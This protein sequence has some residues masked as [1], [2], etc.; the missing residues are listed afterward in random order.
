[1]LFF[2][3][4]SIDPR[5]SDQ[6][7]L[8]PYYVNVIIGFIGHHGDLHTSK[9]VKIPSLGMLPALHILDD[10]RSHDLSGWVCLTLMLN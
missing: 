6:I 3:Q 1:M 8:S 5:I 10:I 4:L 2:M 9:Q 7:A